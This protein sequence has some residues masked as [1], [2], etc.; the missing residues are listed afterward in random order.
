MFLILF[1]YSF[2]NISLIF[3]ISLVLDNKACVYSFLVF[4]FS[5]SLISFLKNLDIFMTS[6]GVFVRI[7]GDNFIKLIGLLVDLSL[8]AVV[9][10][11]VFLG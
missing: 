8:L 5:V 6:L 10:V 2:G 3:K 1:T 4:F 9:L 7:S 11:L